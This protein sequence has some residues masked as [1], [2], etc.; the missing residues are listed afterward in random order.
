[1][2]NRS[3]QKALDLSHNKAGRP[4]VL[5]LSASRL[6]PLL[7]AADPF[8]PVLLQGLICSGLQ[9]PLLLQ[10]CQTVLQLHPEEKNEPVAPSSL[11]G[12]GSV[13]SGSRK[14]VLLLFVE[15]HS[16]AELLLPSG[17]DPPDHLPLLLQQEFF[18]LLSSCFQNF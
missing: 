8:L 1:M 6:L 2:K 14:R 3:R 5:Q 18:V 10:S 7:C 17:L 9:R 13:D 15:G 11:S 4:Q 12:S 16:F